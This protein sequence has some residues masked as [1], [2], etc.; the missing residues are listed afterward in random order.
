M[1]KYIYSFNEIINDK[2]DPAEIL[3]NKGSGLNLMTNLGLPVPQGFT[4]STRV[5]HYYQK[6]NSLPEGF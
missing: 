5:N 4:I 2:I 3:G 1:E 6:N